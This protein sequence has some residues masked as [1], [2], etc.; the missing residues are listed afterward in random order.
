MGNKSVISGLEN[1]IVMEL[2]KTGNRREAIV[3]TVV[4]PDITIIAGG[5][6]ASFLCRHA[7]EGPLKKH[8][9]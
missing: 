5:L 6:A 9:L 8:K 1:F 2:C 7:V 3:S 4:S